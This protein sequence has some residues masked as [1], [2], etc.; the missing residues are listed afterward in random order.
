MHEPTKNSVYLDRRAHQR[1]STIR[2]TYEERVRKKTSSSQII[3]RALT[4][5]AAYLKKLRN[6]GAWVAEVGDLKD[7]RRRHDM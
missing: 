7:H 1:L 3:R 4:L 2:A 5:L 6:E